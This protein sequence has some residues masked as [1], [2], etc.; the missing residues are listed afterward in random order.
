MVCH[1]SLSMT[2]ALN[3]WNDIRVVPL[4]LLAPWKTDL[5]SSTIWL[6]LSFLH[7]FTEFLFLGNYR[8][9]WTDNLEMSSNEMY[10][11]MARSSSVS[12]D[13]TQLSCCV[14]VRWHHQPD[15]SRWT[16]CCEVMILAL[17][18][19]HCLH[20]L[21]NILVFLS[22]CFSAPKIIPGILTKWTCMKFK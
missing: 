15:A 2:A 18:F 3:S 8:S 7:L 1:T 20:P 14:D 12:V 9:L 5:L 4:L 22:L 10:F 19:V 13:I 17:V 6:V 11:F 16:L 21:S